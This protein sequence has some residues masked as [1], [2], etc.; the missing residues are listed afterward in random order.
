MSLCRYLPT[1]SDRMGII[2]SLLAVEGSI[3]LEY[4]PAGTTHFSMGLYGTLGVDF[5]QRLFTTHMSEDDVVM[6]DVTRLE[7]AIVELD[8]SYEPQVIFVVASSISAVIG[9]DIKG[10]C[11]YMQ[12]EVCAKLVAFEQGG[13]RGDYSVGLAEVYKLLVK[14]LP[15]AAE[16]DPQKYNIL[17]ASM[18]RYRMASDVWEIK[19]MLAE[20]YGLTAQACLCCNT[21]VEEIKGMGKVALNIV[22]CAEALEAAEYL[23][24]KFGTPYIYCVPYGYKRTLEFLQQLG[25]LLG[26][27]PNMAMMTRLGSKMRNFGMLG[28]YAAMLGGKKQRPSAVVKGDYD[29]VCGIGGFLA[30]AGFAVEHKICSHTLKAVPDAASDVKFYGEEKDWLDIFRSLHGALVLADDIALMQCSADNTCLRVS[31]PFIN[32]SQIA[33]HLPLMGEKGADFL[34]ETIELYYQNLN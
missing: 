21:S 26:K 28:M 8:R 33:T 25:A 3:V 17:G 19:N 1:P 6:G 22:L 5:E 9:T 4:G 24:E 10:V 34:L 31:A 27:M 12:Q 29:L 20:A 14:N 32:G 11:N 13:F 7:E 18:G 30:E 15:E 2:W 16:K 23:K